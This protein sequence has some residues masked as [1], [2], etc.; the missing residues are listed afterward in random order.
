MYEID[1][2]T[3]TLYAE[4][5]E[6]MQIVEASRTIS[7][8]KGSFSTKE[9]KGE[10]YVYFRVYNLAGQLEELYIGPRKVCHA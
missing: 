3:Q 4:L 8:L 2:Q 7:S 10:E 1:I 6:M 5:L 9:V